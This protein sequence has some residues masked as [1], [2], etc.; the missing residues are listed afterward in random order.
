MSDTEKTNVTVEV[1]VENAVLTASAKVDLVGVLRDI[2][3][4]SKNT[5]D[6]ALVEMVSLA[7]QGLDWKG[8]AKGIL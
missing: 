6:D 4:D 3:K 1:K 7:A 5:I 2:A 8:Y